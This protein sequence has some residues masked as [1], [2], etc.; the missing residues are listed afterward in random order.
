MGIYT[1]VRGEGVKTRLGAA[2]R[3]PK[4]GCAVRQVPIDMCGSGYGSELTGGGGGGHG[5]RLKRVWGAEALTKHQF[6]PKLHKRL[7]RCRAVRSEYIEGKGKAG[8]VNCQRLPIDL[9]QI[10]LHAS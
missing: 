5:Q 3:Q 6:A 4:Q 9:V 2:A 1:D 10:G 7:D 8:C